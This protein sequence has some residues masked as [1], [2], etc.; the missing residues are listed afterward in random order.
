MSRELID[1]QMCGDTIPKKNNRGWPSYRKKKYCSRECSAKAQSQK[2]TIECDNCGEEMRRS[3][4]HVNDSFNY[5]SRDCRSLH[6]TVSCTCEACGEEFRRA[7]SALINRRTGELYEHTYCSM[8]CQ[9]IGKRVEHRDEQDRRSPKDIEWRKA[10]LERDNYTC[11]M[12]GSQENLE[13]HHIEP[14]MDSPEL[15]HDVS[16]GVCVCHECHYYEIHDGAP[17]L[18][19]GRYAK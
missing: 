11:Q 5:C 19:H 8:E 1:C 12:C 18:Q 10:V 16:N 4:S 15:R 3:P 7:K 6:N 14:Y 2:V 17:N 13:A 9:G